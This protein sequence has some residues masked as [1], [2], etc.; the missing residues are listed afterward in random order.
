VDV[1]GHVS[2]ARVTQSLDR[3]FGLDAAALAAARQWTFT[4]GELKGEKVPVAV[5]LTLAFRL[6]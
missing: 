3:V 4:P 5:R 6:H 2:R 1:D